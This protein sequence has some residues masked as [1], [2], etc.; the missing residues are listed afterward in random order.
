M[1]FDNLKYGCEDVLDEEIYVVV[2]V[3]Y[4]DSFVCKLLDGY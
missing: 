3:V 2:K 4:V 1:I